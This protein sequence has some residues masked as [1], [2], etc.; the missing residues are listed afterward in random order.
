MPSIQEGEV[1]VCK[2]FWKNDKS[3]GWQFQVTDYEVEL[4]STIAG[5]K[6]YL[7]S[8]MIK[9]IG[10]VFAERIVHYFGKE[11]L[12]VID[13][14]PDQLVEVSGIGSKR[15]TTIK[16]HWKEQRA[17]RDVMMFLQS[18]GISP[19]YAQKVYK[20]YG[21]QSISKI[22]SNPYHLSKDIYGIG[23]KTA[24]KIAFQLG[25]KRDAD[26][27]I[28][29]GVEF[30]LFELSNRGHTCYPVPEF[31]DA[32]RKLLE[33]PAENIRER[34][35]EIEL[36]YRI[37]VDKLEEGENA[38]D[39]IWLMGIYNAEKGIT[40]SVKKLLSATPVFQVNGLEDAIKKA[41]R[42]L[43][44]ELAVNQK[45]GDSKEFTIEIAHHYWWTRNWK[46][47]DYK[48]HFTSCSN[49]YQENFIS[50]ANRQSCQ[51]PSSG[52]RTECT[53]YSQFIRIRFFYQWLSSKCHKSPQW[54]INH[55][56]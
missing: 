49:L 23:F 30:V 42:E 37:L 55:S 16:E 3:Y 28:D 13:E 45:K 18:Q 54:R 56:R 53:N 26:E 20:Q 19:M 36:N 2:G 14:S 48:S 12:K 51:T 31:L 35:R 21:D 17:I 41:E 24:D 40:N 15:V 33:V 44:I 9:G 46:I 29:A 5:I 10:N 11:T 32:A 8:G 34:L 39:F 38:E 1:V 6:K 43:S 50:C 52:H 25:I 7:G 4:P 47:D 27:R 22:Q